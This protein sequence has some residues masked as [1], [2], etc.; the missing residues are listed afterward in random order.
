MSERPTIPPPMAKDL[1]LNLEKLYAEPALMREL[2]AP[3]AIRLAHH[4]SK[5]A[6]TLEKWAKSL[7]DYILDRC[8]PKSLPAVWDNHATLQMLR[9]HI[10]GLAAERD[11]WRRR[12]KEAEQMASE[13][14]TRW[15]DACRR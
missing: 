4:Y 10:D 6:E 12:A 8:R 15:K 2:K 1:A 9:Q 11:E 13:M 14:R 3:A 7:Q 5:E